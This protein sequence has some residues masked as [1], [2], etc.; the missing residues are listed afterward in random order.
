MLFVPTYQFEH[1]LEVI[2]AEL[3]VS[4]TIPPGK[5]QWAFRLRFGF[6]GTP[7]P[8]FLGRSTSADTFRDLRNQIP[9]FNFDDDLNKATKEGQQYQHNIFYTINSLIHMKKGSKS[10]KNRLKWTYAHRSWGRSIKRV[11]RYLGLRC[12]VSGDDAPLSEMPPSLSLEKVIPY[13]PEGL[14]VFI[15]I[16]LEAWE[17]DNNLIT[18]VGIA[19]LDTQRIRTVPPGRNGKNWFDLISA[20]HIRVKENAW[21]RNERFVL[22]CPDRFNFG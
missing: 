7:R 8:R 10:D 11:Q 4:F 15:A 21:A 1:L 20:R 5:N 16:D 13:E 22:G 6:G 19:V 9:P 3:E 12:K 2:N 14:P 17:R 18:E